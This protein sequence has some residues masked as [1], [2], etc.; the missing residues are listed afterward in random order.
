V[1]NSFE[2]HVVNKTSRTV[3]FERHGVPRPELSYVVSM[4][5]LVVPE[6]HDQRIPVFSDF[7]L[8]SRHDGDAA[9]IE[10][11]LDGKTVSTLRAPLLGP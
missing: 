8:H 11:K 3:R 4:P 2:V 10:L 9:L 7:P 5:Q 1:R 6:L